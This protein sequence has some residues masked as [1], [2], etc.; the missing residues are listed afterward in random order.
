[1][2]PESNL[3]YTKEYEY[4]LDFSTVLQTA[5]YDSLMGYKINCVLQLAFFFF[6]FLKMEQNLLEHMALGR[7][8]R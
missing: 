2:W 6:F 5:S 4:V 1:M 3:S 8:N 7:V